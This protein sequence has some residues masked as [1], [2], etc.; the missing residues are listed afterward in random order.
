MGVSKRSYGDLLFDGEVKAVLQLVACPVL[1]IPAGWP[2]P[3]I[4]HVIFATDLA[5][6]DV[7]VIA[8]LVRLSARLKARVSLSHV[9]R[10]VLIP[11]FAEELRTSSFT[12][13]VMHLYPGIGCSNL[14]AA[15]VMGALEQLSTEKHADLIELR[16][17]KHPVWYRLFNENPLKEAM[18]HS[19]TPLLIF[20]E[21]P[22]HHD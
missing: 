18:Q 4:G 3:E 15:N 13:R 19:Q 8:E 16:Y 21:N 10:P 17:R 9:S 14:R 2:G 5:E 20:P 1:V 7:R 12:D 6:A 22:G 11:D